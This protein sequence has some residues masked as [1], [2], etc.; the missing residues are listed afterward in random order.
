M[1]L[2]RAQIPNTSP[3]FPSIHRH[4]TVAA[5]NLRHT[6]LLSSLYRDSNCIHLR[7]LQSRSAGGADAIFR[8]TH[9]PRTSG[10][11]HVGAAEMFA[12]LSQAAYCLAYDATPS[13]F[14]EHNVTNCY[15]DS[16][17]VRFQQMLAPC[18]EYPLS[19]F[20]DYGPTGLPVL[21]FSG[22][23]SGRATCGFVDSTHVSR[24]T[25]CSETCSLPDSTDGVL[26]TFYNNGAELLLKDFRKVMNREFRCSLRTPRDSRLRVCNYSTT[27][28]IMVG[29]SQVS[30]AVAG[31]L[32]E[33][34][35]SALQWSQEEFLATMADQTVVQLAYTRAP[36]VDQ[37]QWEIDVGVRAAKVVRDSKFIRLNLGGALNGAMDSMASPRVPIRS[38]V[39]N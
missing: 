18:E 19:I 23:I 25:T 35:R 30:F 10:Y 3:R 12:G 32:S 6:A 14:T 31:E 33:S 37:Q 1:C 7:S 28:Q 27:T 15:F 4:A 2:N 39:L 8:F 13:L 21:N 16:M 22:F 38:Q 24:S 26:R 34:N 5:M 17:N 9:N 11:T 36:G 20:L 29:L